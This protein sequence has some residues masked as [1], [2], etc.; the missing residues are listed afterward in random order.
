MAPP[1]GIGFLIGASVSPTVSTAFGTVEQKIQ[2]MKQS[3]GAASKEAKT[4]Q[5]ALNLRASRDDISAKYKASGGTD[6]ALRKELAK[7]SAEYRK[8]KISALG[9][10]GSVADWSAKQAAASRQLEASAARLRIY[11]DL[12][13]QTKKRK[14][15]RGQMMGAV[16]GAMTVAAPIK[17]AI[18]FESAMAD[19]AKTIDGMRDDSGKLTDKYYGMETAIKRMGRALP[20]TH[21][22]LASLFAAGGQ[23]GYTEVK[24]LEEFTTMAAHMSVAF[25][26]STEEAADAIGGYRSAMHLSFADTRT[27]L[28]LM[29]Q[30]AN[31]TS[32]SE[33]GIADV[34]RRI[35]PLGNVGGVAAKPM[36]ALAA[37][38][39]AMKV[40]PE[41]AATGIKNL[42]LSM[43]AGTAA[44]KK[45]RAAFGALG[46]DTVKLA[47]QMQTDGPAAIISVLESIKEL[48]K[49]QQL[50]IMQ[51]IFGRESLGAIAPLLD[52]LDQVKKNLVIAGDTS[53]YA[54]AMQKEFENRS[55]TTANA[56][57]LAK[58][59]AME[60][61][62]SIGAVVLPSLV[63]LLETVGPWISALADIAGRHKTVTT[64]LVGV[65]AGL[66]TVR[67]GTLATMY[68]MS[69]V[70]SV[71]LAVRAAF[72]LLRGATLIGTAAQW[73]LNAAMTANPIGIVVAGIGALVAAMVFLYNTCEPVRAA[74]D[75]V[76]G[77]IGAKAAWL[78]EKVS[79][80]A[81]AFRAIGGLFKSGDDSGEKDEQVP[82]GAT[83]KPG[84][85]SAAIP[86]L[87]MPD[88][89]ALNPQGGG[90]PV[91]AMPGASP[92]VSASFS[93]NINGAP[94]RQFSDGVM[95][96][97]KNRQ[98]EIEQIISS[99]VHD[100]M[101]VAYGS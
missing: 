52:S 24:D 80:I 96:A 47:K 45:Q 70:R 101:R 90:I 46:I 86:A 98:S 40:A 97:L 31:T 19:A 3:L 21:K 5:R 14:E 17:A 92:S 2:N 1:F 57:V 10:G 85:G 7:V 65:A 62:I 71:A 64:V 100:Q 68:A 32:A 25:G 12:Q 29:N 58:N 82:E 75:T 34:V 11:N 66:F 87:R 63:S 49:A 50:S 69:A 94:D 91:A 33:K 89:S 56:L 48:P 43:T 20:L 41:V 15:M 54:G 95:N 51:Q 6:S 83:D 99:I 77:W 28:D 59:R 73:A 16:V 4:M 55:K 39:D 53:K 42:I 79:A 76:F 9:Y 72:L 38:L 26:M 81:K 67:L 61:G 93:F 84:A 27:M 44:T 36:T 8:A 13:A 35:G 18:D 37:T 78:W 30:F 88:L 60:M 23:Q 74:F 22:E